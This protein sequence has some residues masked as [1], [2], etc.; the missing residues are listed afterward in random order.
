MF[1]KQ[2]NKNDHVRVGVWFMANRKSSYTVDDIPVKS[3]TN[4]MIILN[5]NEKVTGIKIQPKKFLFL[6][7]LMQMQ[8]IPNLKTVYKVINNEFG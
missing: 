6:N 1:Y 2:Q 4:G 5:T 3:I 7:Y 8:P